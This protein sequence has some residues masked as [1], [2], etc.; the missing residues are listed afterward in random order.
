MV[1]YIIRRYL[2]LQ[3]PRTLMKA[4]LMASRTPVPETRFTEDVGNPTLTICMLEEKT[5]LFVQ[6]SDT[7]TPPPLPV[8]LLRQSVLDL[9]DGNPLLS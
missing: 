1:V 9:P 2:T 3:L 7:L 4:L 8:I 5:R 6:A